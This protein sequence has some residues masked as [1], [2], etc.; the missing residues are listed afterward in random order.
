[1]SLSFRCRVTC[2][3]RKRCYPLPADTLTV[4][5]LRDA[6]FKIVKMANDAHV[7]G[8]CSAGT[9]NVELR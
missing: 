4:R 5:L 9:R 7:A 2:L 6:H 3:R 8:K 1:M